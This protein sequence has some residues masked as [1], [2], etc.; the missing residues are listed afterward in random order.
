[1]FVTIKSK[2]DNYLSWRL[3]KDLNKAYEQTFGK[4]RVFGQY[5]LDDNDILSYNLFV[6]HDYNDFINSGNN[7]WYS[8]L[9]HRLNSVTVYKLIGAAMAF[10]TSLSKKYSTVMEEYFMDYNDYSITIGP[11]AKSQNYM[12]NFAIV[13]AQE[14]GITL[15]L[16]SETDNVYVLNFYSDAYQFNDF[17]Q[18]AF[19]LSYAL[20]SNFD[21]INDLTKEEVS[22]VTKYGPSFVR[23]LKTDIFKRWIVHRL[24]KYKREFTDLFDYDYKVKP[25]VSINKEQYKTITDLMI[26]LVLGYSV[27]TV[28]D[29][30]CGD[31]RL[32]YYLK[33]ANPKLIITG[34]DKNDYQVNRA[35]RLKPNYFDGKTIDNGLYS[36][37][38]FK[39]G[40]LLYP[41]M[42]DRPDVVIL[43]NVVST[44]S[45]E[46]Q[47][48][49]YFR[50][51]TYYKPKFIIATEPIYT[52]FKYDKLTEFDNS[53]YLF[54]ID[55]ETN[56]EWANE[57]SNL[58][59]FD[60]RLINNGLCSDRFN[61]NLPFIGEVIAPNQ[62][63]D[64]IY[65][66]NI[67]NSVRDFDHPIIEEYVNGDRYS[68]E[69]KRNISLTAF[70]NQTGQPFSDLSLLNQLF[71]ELETNLPSNIQH[72]IFDAMV[73]P[74]QNK[75]A[76]QEYGAAIECALIDYVTKDAIE[77]TNNK[78][79]TRLIDANLAYTIYNQMI[80]HNQLEIVVFDL[81]KINY[82]P[83]YPYLKSLINE[84][85]DILFTKTNIFRPVLWVKEESINMMYT[86]IYD[87]H[88]NGAIIRENDN[89]IMTRKVRRFDYLRFQYGLHYA[90]HLNN[91][92]NKKAIVAIGLTMCQTELKLK[93]VDTSNKS[94]KIVLIAKSIGIEQKT[95]DNTVGQA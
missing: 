66:E 53:V 64:S 48:L 8:Y 40:N 35:R 17:L 67:A 68:F 33:H 45:E 61:P 70:N 92:K 54:S 29:L 16:L 28:L 22:K 36:G 62:Q 89:P 15:T 76:K 42:I 80:K 95:I 23:D 79:K 32:D 24:T 46:D 81:L 44:L 5:Q 18:K 11:F 10:S 49:L 21:D 59:E 91:I 3:H 73:T 82:V 78:H 43:S 41:V 39:K 13:L 6:E 4:R 77:P 7:S 57:T 20:V 38:T 27:N 69:F 12:H 51:K 93:T 71:N 85:I 83:A 26:E 37:L 74:W 56:N 65:L 47:Q 75:N 9:N 63:A 25:K 55:Y 86:Y 34:I 58:S 52:N 90:S 1:M 72:L 87:N 14:L 60:I 31:G 2:S 84:Q 50:L 94:E 88:I 19:V 30:G